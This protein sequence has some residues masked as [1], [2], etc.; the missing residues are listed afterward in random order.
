MARKV[1][2]ERVVKEF[3]SMTVRVSS[4]GGG[5]DFFVTEDDSVPLDKQNHFSTPSDLAGYFR[6]K[7]TRKVPVNSPINTL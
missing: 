1:S 5:R 6:D 4:F 3:T 2:T 7:F